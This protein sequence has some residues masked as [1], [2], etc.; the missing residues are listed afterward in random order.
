MMVDS[1][2]ITAPKCG[3]LPSYA[4]DSTIIISTENRFKA[5]ER[6]NGLMDRVKIFLDANTLSLNTGKTEIVECMVR[7]KRVHQTG[8]PP[9]LTVTLPD[10]NLKVINAKESCRLL[11]GNVNQDINWNHHLEQGEKPL[12]KSLRSILGILSHL[13]SNMPQKSRLLLANGLFLSR[14]LYLLPMW[15]ETSGQG[16]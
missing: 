1:S 9:Q 14:L 5:Q 13:S 4:D 12:M 7:Q 3:Q 15:G 2:Q 6:I 8:A 16:S 11:G 10:G